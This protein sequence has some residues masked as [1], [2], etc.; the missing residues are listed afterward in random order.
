MK[1]KLLT[2]KVAEIK[3]IGTEPTWEN[4]T[5]VDR[6]ERLVRAF[7]W[8]NYN[9][10][11]K[12]AKEMI[13][14]WLKS[15]NRLGDHKKFQKVN[16]SDI[17]ITIA[18]LCRCE[19]VGLKL[20][21]QETQQIEKEIKNLLNPSIVVTTKESPEEEKI[22]KP[23]I[24]DRLREK[25]SEC[26]AELEGIFDDFV[27]GGCKN[28]SEISPINTIRSMNV[29][30]NL[31]GEIKSIWQKRLDELVLAQSGKEKDL[32]EAY[33]CFG[34]IQLRNMIKFSE[35]VIADCDS[36]V[37]VKKVERKP[38]AKKKVSPETLAAKIRYQKE[39]PSLGL[40]SESPAKLVESSEVWLYDTKKRKLMYYVADSHAGKM[41]VKGTAII[42][43]DP[44]L[45][46]QKT[47]RKPIDI[48][49]AFAKSTKVAM[50]KTYKEIN[51]TET[52]LSGRLTETMIIIKAHG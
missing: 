45:S 41:T 49:P 29:F 6:K 16:D 7:N 9:Y 2:P 43:F 28:I 46:T 33:S 34:K 15:K 24:Q 38:R 1:L 26:A 12:E 23:N 32:A 25:M 31:I 4:C 27:L 21:E 44:T 8:Y 20:T 47:V 35:T 30:P 18:W 40:K 10:G 36:Y 39:E 19:L 42:G 52:K 37:Q 3:Y 11:K 14:D 5:S 13:S 48:I 17:R 51:S 22:T 50:R